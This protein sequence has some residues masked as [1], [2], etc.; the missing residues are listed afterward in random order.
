MYRPA[1][2]AEDRVEVLHALIHAHPLATLV[3]A[4]P[5]GLAADHLP[6]LIDPEPGPYGTLRGHVARANPLWRAAAGAE[7]L[8]VFQGPEAYVTPGWYP[9]KQ[10]TGK[11]VPTWNYVVVHAHGRLRT[12]D[13]AAWLRDLVGALTDRHEAPRA[14]PWQVS[15]A[16]A[17]F[18]AAQLQAI[19]GIEIPL[20]R[21]QGK[22]KM[23]QNRTPAD[24]D[25]VRA[26]L[27]SRAAGDDAAV[28]TLV[29]RLS[30]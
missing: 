23:S 25:G 24:R 9:S 29:G 5:R 8:V 14:S 22:W 20:E 28:A 15:D 11:V 13:N 2:F 26:G 10:E 7:V 30:R 3:H 16:P 1:H 21:L 4:G 19:V 12:I 27:E 17:D 18:V 6:F